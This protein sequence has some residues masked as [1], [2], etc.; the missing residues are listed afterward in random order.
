MEGGVIVG[1]GGAKSEEVLPVD[2]IGMWRHRKEQWTARVRSKDGVKVGL[3]SAVFGTLSQN[4]S[5]LMSPTDV[6]SV[7][8]MLLDGSPHHQ[9]Q[10]MYSYIAMS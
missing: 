9:M 1:S 8:D 4:T 6:W 5:T 7:T 2:F 3:T 10:A